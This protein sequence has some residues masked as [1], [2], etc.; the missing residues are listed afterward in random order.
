MQKMKIEGRDAV[1]RDERFKTVTEDWNEYETASGVTVR[2][3][4]V[5]H[6]IARVLDQNGKPSFNKDGDPHMA[7]RTQIQ[8]VTSGGPTEEDEVH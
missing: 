6:K 8:V 5:V 3:K 4:T 2:V 7:V 1:V